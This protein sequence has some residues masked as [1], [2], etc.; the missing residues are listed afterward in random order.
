MEDSSIVIPKGEEDY[1]AAIEMLSDTNWI[2]QLK[3]LSSTKEKM[4]GFFGMT[5]PPKAS[6]AKDQ[7][8]DGT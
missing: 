5:P 3:T 2:D 6:T 8:T 4:Y 7:A 1:D